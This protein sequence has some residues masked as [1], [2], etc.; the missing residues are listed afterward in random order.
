MVPST[1]TGLQAVRHHLA[2]GLE[3]LP[4]P[5]RSKTAMEM[6]RTS[7]PA[8]PTRLFLYRTRSPERRFPH[9]GLGLLVTLLPFLVFNSHTPS[10]GAQRRR[11]L[12]S[13]TNL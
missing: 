11:T 12:V 7:P 9:L 2:Q 4:S 1:S 5:R 8:A 6:L 3:M 13:V 10:R